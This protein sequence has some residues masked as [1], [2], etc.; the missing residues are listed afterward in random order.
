MI[1][2]L[3]KAVFLAGLPVGIASY[4]L[5]WWAIRSQYLQP[6]TDL[7][8]L[9]KEVSRLSKSK[10]KKKKDSDPGA[11][12]AR[13]NPVH[14]KWLAFGG[15][16]YG[17][18][19]LMTFVI[20]EAGEVLSFLGNFSENLGMLSRLGFDLVIR[21]VIDSIMNFVKAIAWPMYWMDR[22]DMDRVWLW[23]LAAYG[24]YWLGAKTAMGVPYSK[25]T[26]A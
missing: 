12:A 2:E 4:L 13:L 10:K 24:G 6:T 21:F 8:K 9:E 25:G 3:F 23:F 19:A 11:P 15:G 18:V 17:V 5:V 26:G 7:K 20:I 1:A 22:I 14:N 16:F